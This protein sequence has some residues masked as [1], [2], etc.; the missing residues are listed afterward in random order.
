MGSGIQT[1][2]VT[3]GSIVTT[4]V[5]IDDDYWNYVTRSR[6]KILEWLQP[7][8]KFVVCETQLVLREAALWCP[9]CDEGLCSSC[10]KH[11]RASKATKNHEVTSVNNYKQLP[12][13]IARRGIQT[14]DITNGRAA[15]T[16][17]KVYDNHD[18]TYVTTSKDKIYLTDQYSST[19]TCYTLTGQKVWECKNETIV[20]S[21]RGVTIDNESNVYMVSYG[22]T[23][24]SHFTRWKASRQLLGKNMGLNILQLSIFTNEEIFCSLL[25]Y[26][27]QPFCIILNDEIRFELCREEYSRFNTQL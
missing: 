24:S 11:H 16:V 8:G 25:A 19:V 13:E 4:V 22:M 21:F 9:E 20:I 14:V 5:K 12:P 23:V 6:D 18:W 17:V 1:V 27:E 2:D 10:E 26:L 15:T 7:V 3:D